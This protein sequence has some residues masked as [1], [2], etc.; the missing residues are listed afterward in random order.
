MQHQ[1]PFSRKGKE[2]QQKTCLDGLLDERF[3]DHRREVLDR[4]VGVWARG[5]QPL[6]EGEDES[7]CE[8][9]LR[10]TLVG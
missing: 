8:I 10:S 4:V 2:K 9:N 7:R 5:F 3:G 6:N 1:N